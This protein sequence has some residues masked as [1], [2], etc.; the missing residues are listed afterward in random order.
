MMELRDL[1]FV[2]LLCIQN[3]ENLGIN[4]I[5]NKKGNNQAIHSTDMGL[6]ISCSFFIL[7]TSVSICK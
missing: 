4:E 7:L 1:H 2:F 6:V 3:C 5:L